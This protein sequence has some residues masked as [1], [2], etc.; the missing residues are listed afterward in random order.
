MRRLPVNRSI[1]LWSGV[2]MIMLLI[3]GAVVILLTNV[4]DD[5]LYGNKRYFFV[6]LLLAYAVYRGFRVK[7]LFRE[8]NEPS[9]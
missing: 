1:S 8:T 2:V 9:D 3:V 7:Q 6:G 5:R 4:L